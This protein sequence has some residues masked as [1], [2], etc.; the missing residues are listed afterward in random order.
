MS[1]IDTE[2]G[3]DYMDPFGGE[4]FDMK[5]RV[6]FGVSLGYQ[7][8]G[9]LSTQLDYLHYG[10][11][12]GR[13]NLAQPVEGDP[14]QGTTSA[15]IGKETLGLSMVAT[16]DLSR[17]IHVGVQAGW[18]ITKSNANLITRQNDGRAWESSEMT[19]SSRPYGGV[20]AG[21]KWSQ[22]I[23]S[24][25]YTFLQFEDSRRNDDIMK[26]ASVALRYNF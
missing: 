12:A 20:V 17:P 6:S 21:Y 2:S 25:E 13:N 9:N 14:F 24:L 1:K 26:A 15:E 4:A 19:E 11:S 22:F 23:I 8:N 10:D 7:F 16:T 3:N 18:G 5:D